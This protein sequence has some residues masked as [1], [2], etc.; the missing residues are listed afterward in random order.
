MWLRP[1][2]PHKQPP[3]G[4]QD[5]PTE[6]RDACNS[7]PP[8]H[9]WP[10]RINQAAPQ[11]I[12]HLDIILLP[13]NTETE[14]VHPKDPVSMSRK[15]GVF[16]SILCAECPRTY[17]GQT[18]RS[19]DM[20]MQECRALQKGDV[21]A[22]AVAEHVFATGLNDVFFLFSL[23]PTSFSFFF[24]FPLPPPFRHFPGLGIILF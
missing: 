9:Q 16:Y 5:L 24:C 1:F 7:D 3:K 22:F 19:L 23:F 13:Q 8:V 6:R 18:G 15:K 10:I 2:H 21:V 20:R 17:I 4:W 12:V 14:L 11:P